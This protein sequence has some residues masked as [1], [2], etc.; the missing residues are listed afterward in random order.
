MDKR[1]LL[2][3]IIT[4]LLMAVYP[5]LIE[6]LGLV[7]AGGPIEQEREDPHDAS[8]ST[9]DSSPAPLP[10]PSPVRP[11]LKPAEEKTVSVDTPLYRAEFG[12]RGGVLLRWELKNYLN[13]EHTEPIVLYKASENGIPPFSI[14]IDDPA[15]NEKFLGDLYAV[16]GGNLVLGPEH[17]TGEIAFRFKDRESGGEIVKRLVFSQD[18]YRMVLD[19]EVLGVE[20][21][22]RVAVGT[23]FGI[24]DWG[25]A[26]G[27]IGFIGPITLIDGRLEKDSPSKLES[28]V[29]HEGPIGWT[30][31]ADKYFLAAAM[32]V[33]GRAVRVS[34][35]GPELVNTEVEFAPKKNGSYRVVFYAGPK[36]HDRLAALGV[37]LEKTVD[38][39]WFIYGSWA[40][41]RFLAEP[42]FYILRFLHGFTGNYGISIILLTVGV[43]VLFIPLTHKSYRSMKSMQVLQPQLQ[44]LQKK[45]KEDKQRLQKEMMALYQKNKVNPVGGCLPMLLQI[46]VFVA[47]FNVLYN[48]IELRQA[49]F[50][51]WIRDLSDKDP[52]YVLPVI[53]GL[54]MLIQQKIQPTTMEPAQ[55][56]MM[57]LLPVF[58]TFLF[59]TFPSGLVLYMITNNVLTV[60]QQFITMKYL[61]EPH[62]K[63]PGKNHTEKAGSPERSRS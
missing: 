9:P 3:L 27:F 31:Q 30:A 53:M 48:T 34:A 20:G 57:L 37:H 56:R 50:Y 26:G 45:F 35:S 51:F 40:I 28:P 52:L 22:V 63:E 32:P 18:N 62:E 58:M 36:E 2:F 54:T 60:A 23:N 46:P 12:T 15:L 61:D 38:F 19:L 13:K 44:A 21:P 59:L 10:S 17:P 25:T 14:L 11:L 7:P 33:D 41:V 47:L 8:P 49:P 16:D 29:R 42:L 6:R 5:F 24:T 1:F 39:G 4:V 55:A 43:R